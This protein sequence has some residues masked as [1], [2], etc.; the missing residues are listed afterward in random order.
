MTKKLFVSS[1]SVL[2]VLLPAGVLAAKGNQQKKADVPQRPNI[3]YIMSDDHAYQAI[4]AYG[5]GLNKT[6]GIDRIAQAGMLF[7]NNFVGNSLS[8]PSRAIVLTGKFSHM[9]GFY[10]NQAG[11]VFDGS[12]T[13]FPK[14]LQKAGYQTAIIGKWHLGSRPTGFDYYYIH[15]GQGTYYSP[16]MVEPHDTVTCTGQYATDVTYNK[17]VEW[18][19]H[20]DKSKPFLLMMHFKAPH[21]NWMPAPDKLEMYE[22]TTFPIPGNFYDNYEGRLAAAQQKMS[23]A[24][25][26]T[27]DGDCKML[28]LTGKPDKNEAAMEYKRMTPEQRAAFDKVYDKIKADFI[29][30]N[31]QGNDLAEWKYQRF[32]RDYMK[33]I[34]SVDDKV[35]LMID[36]LKKNGLWDNTIVIYTSDQGFFLGEHG[37]FDKRWIYEESFHS[38]LLVSYPPMIKAG[39]ENKSLVQNIDFAPTLLDLAGVKVP[40]EMQGE[41]LKPILDGEKDKVRDALYYHYYEYPQPHGVARHYGIRDERYK[42]VHFYYGTD[43]WELYDLQNDPHEMHNLIDD[44]AYK[45]II[46]NMKVKLKDLQV[47][48]Q[49][50]NPM[51]TY[52]LD[53]K[54]VGVKGFGY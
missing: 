34:S 2:T 21:R 54:Q 8:G 6:P 31:P 47:K 11:S 43:A 17:C 35:G 53:Q 14:L 24:K 15:V 39:V 3:L 42:L 10:D 27:V 16:V 4:S 19:D 49:D 28:G 33:C 5:Y 37:W 41:S 50:T 29:A 46:A 40:A 44:P 51:D 48:Y 25:D 7:R 13:T 32:M 52:P 1:A 30:R 23:I 22:D 18:L 20:R 9:N 38:P 12:Q 36:Y 26:M 45:D